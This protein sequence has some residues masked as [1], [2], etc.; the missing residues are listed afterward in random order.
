MKHNTVE[1]ALAEERLAAWREAV[2]INFGRR[3]QPTVCSDHFKS[4]I[5]LFPLMTGY[6]HLKFYV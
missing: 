4:G 6:S 2:P 1:I 3:K 5:Y